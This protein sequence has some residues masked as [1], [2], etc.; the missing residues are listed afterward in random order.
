MRLDDSGL[1]ANIGGY[2][3]ILSAKQSSLSTSVV[4][5]KPTSGFFTEMH[6]PLISP[7]GWFVFFCEQINASVSTCDPYVYSLFNDTIYPVMVGTV[8]PALKT[9]IIY[10]SWSDSNELQL[11]GY[12]SINPQTPWKLS[13]ND[14]SVTVT[15]EN[16]QVQ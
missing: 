5:S 3:R 6:K 10:V 9:D 8:A 2:E 13:E 4:Q 11:N 1:Y 16:P 14:V 15:E 7:D 12:S